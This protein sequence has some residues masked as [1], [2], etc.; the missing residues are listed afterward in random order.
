[1]ITMTLTL[2]SVAAWLGLQWMISHATSWAML[3]RMPSWRA[4][5]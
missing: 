1:M 4:Q 5:A 2:L 3:R